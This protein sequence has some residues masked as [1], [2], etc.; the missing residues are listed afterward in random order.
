LFHSTVNVVAVGV[1]KRTRP[2]GAGGGLIGGKGT[3]NVEGLDVN[4]EAPDVNIV[5]T[6]RVCVVPDGNPDNVAV[7]DV[8]IRAVPAPN[9]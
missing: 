8:V 4:T 5:R 7:V 3:D 6:V 1:P 2:V 9:T